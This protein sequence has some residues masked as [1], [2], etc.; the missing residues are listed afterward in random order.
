MSGDPRL[1]GPAQS[2][3]G[4]LLEPDRHLGPQ[5]P[6]EQVAIVAIPRRGVRPSSPTAASRSA[7]GA[8]S[9]LTSPRRGLPEP[10]EW[11]VQVERERRPGPVSGREQARECGELPGCIT[12]PLPRRLADRAGHRFVQ[13]TARQCSG[14]L[15]QRLDH[16]GWRWCPLLVGTQQSRQERRHVRDRRAQDGRPHPGVLP[17]PTRQPREGLAAAMVVPVTHGQRDLKPDP[18]IRIVGQLY[19]RLGH[20]RGATKHRPDGR[21]HASP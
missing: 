4:R 13:A 18:C 21:D 8:E 7:S 16:L 11:L 5:H 17:V 6:K 15:Q 9:S 3:Y 10:G 1:G 12:P 14:D 19:H 2:G 20:L